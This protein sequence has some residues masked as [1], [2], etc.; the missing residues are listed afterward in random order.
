MTKRLSVEGVRLLDGKPRDFFLGHCG[1]LDR[2]PLAHVWISAGYVRPEPPVLYRVCYCPEGFNCI[3]IEHQTK[4]GWRT[5][6]RGSYARLRDIITPALE[7]AV[8][9]GAFNT[10]RSGEKIA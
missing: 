8:K 6:A 4:A 9:R 2:M 10:L 1:S 3:T 5:C 7:A